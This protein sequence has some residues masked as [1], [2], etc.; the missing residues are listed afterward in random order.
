LYACQVTLSYTLIMVVMTF[1]LWLLLAVIVGEALGYL[2]FSAE[3]S[4]EECLYDA[5]SNEM[6]GACQ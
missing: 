3:P 1:N 6:R 2:L 5:S 4:S